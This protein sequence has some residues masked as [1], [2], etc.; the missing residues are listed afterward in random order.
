M[1][2]RKAKLALWWRQSG[3]RW[4]VALFV[5]LCVALLFQVAPL[6]EHADLDESA[7]SGSSLLVI[8]TVN[9]NISILLVLAFLVGRNVVKLIFDRRR[10]ILGSRLRQRLVL[11][12][13]G[14]ALIPTSILFLLANGLLT[15]T[16]EEWFSAQIEGAVSGAVG[17]A[18]VYHRGM[19][20]K[21]RSSIKRLVDEL[22]K[23]RLAGVE[24]ERDFFEKRRIRK[25]LFG[26]RVYDR[27]G[28]HLEVQNAAAII[29]SFKQPEANPESIRQ[30][31][32]GEVLVQ[33]EREGPSQFIRAY[34]KGLLNQNEIVVVTTKRLPPELTESI[35][36]INDAYKGYE[37]LKVFRNP[38]RSGYILTLAMITGLI[39][40]AAIW[41]GFYIAR[42]IS[43]PIQRI[44]E[45]TQQVAR[46]NYGFQIR[47]SGNDELSYLARSFNQMTKDL[48]LSTEVAE[49]RRVYIETVLAHLV[50]GVITLD[51]EGKITSINDAARALLG[52]DGELSLVGRGLSEIMVEDDLRQV[53]TLLAVAKSEVSEDENAEVLLEL[54]S[55]GRE[56]RVI[57]TSGKLLN[58]AGLSIG[59][60]LLFDDV[61]ELSKA[62]QMSAWREVARR[63]AHE[64]KNPLTPIQLSAQRLER[65]V[66]EGTER[67]PAAI[68]ECV[69]TIVQNVDSIKRLANEFSHFARLPT[70]EFVPS[71]LNTLVADAVS[72][73]AMSHEKIVFQFLPDDK[74]PL[75]SMDKE[76]MR[77]LVINLID[78][79]IA[80]VSEIEPRE[81]GRIVLKTNYDRKR[82]AAIIEIA[83]NGVGIPDQVKGRIFDPYFTTKT[84]GTGIGL[85]IVTTIVNDHQGSIRVY[86]NQPRGTKFIVEISLSPNITPTQ[87][88]IAPKEEWQA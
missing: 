64:I 74:L 40:F 54:R 43:V 23:V 62:Q 1:V 67:D 73:F 18:R 28:L 57:C 13:V 66:S 46:G 41:I 9:L 71:N 37:E 39:I 48:R 17:V 42:D 80:A 51:R 2:S 35:E 45:G 31:F 12:F 68:R 72:S 65:L 44:A 32:A 85:A 24:Q 26:I 16:M 34:A 52:S 88:K 3:T 60:L 86:D 78:N 27:K 20:D 61:T 77:R 10:N 69:E 56:R 76:Q 6:R 14:L 53:E 63:I 8:L 55:E 58:S 70:A 22:D 21:E 29:E 5:L 82:R 7:W 11:A 4:R 87:R 38:L 25:G 30:A 19:I 75:V 49:D 36:T 81:G 33:H 59:T 50:V 79:A 15:K 83:D 47:V 84:S